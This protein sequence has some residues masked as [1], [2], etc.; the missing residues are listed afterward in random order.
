MYRQRFKDLFSEQIVSYN[1]EDGA[2]MFDTVWAAVLAL[3]R[4]AAMGHLLTNFNYENKNISKIIYN[5]A[6]KVEFFGL[7]VSKNSYL[8]LI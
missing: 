8:W 2:F 6:L 3:N 7:T 4:T 1:L 5:E